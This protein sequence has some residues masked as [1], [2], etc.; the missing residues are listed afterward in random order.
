MVRR[1]KSRRLDIIAYVF[2]AWHKNPYKLPYISPYWEMH[3]KRKF[4]ALTILLSLIFILANQS[5][6]M[7]HIG[8]ITTRST[9]D[10]DPLVDIVL[11]VEFLSVRA[12]DAIDTTSDP[13][14]FI[15]VFVNN[16]GYRSPIWYDT[17]TLKNFW[18]ITANVPDDQ[19]FVNITILLFDSN[20][21][22]DRLCDISK[23]ENRNGKGY[24]VNLTYE[25]KTGRWSGDDSIGD[26]SGYGRVCGCDDGSR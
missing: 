7:Q 19:E 11:T 18:N 17:P 25:L 9:M 2:H 14:F 10:Y 3:M 21:D 6:S 5:E 26:Y 16:N 4:V 1:N 24:S 20:S 23:D 8:G 15:K 13:D 22:M 12:L